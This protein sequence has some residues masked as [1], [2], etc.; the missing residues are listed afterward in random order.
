MKPRH[1]AIM[2]TQP[3]FAPTAVESQFEFV[4]AGKPD[5]FFYLSAWHS[6]GRR[7]DREA[8]DLADEALH[9]TL[10]G[11]RQPVAYFRI[12][13][14]FPGDDPGERGWGIA[15]AQPDAMELARRFRASHIWKFTAETVA[16]IRV[17]SGEVVHT[18]P[19][20]SHHR[21]PRD[22]RY[23]TLA[24]GSPPDRRSLAPSEI[25]DVRT[26]IG[27][28]FPGFTIQRAEGCFRTLSEETLLIHIATH[29]PTKVIALAHDLRLLLRQT[30][31]GIVHNGI[32][33]RVREWTDDGMILE[34]F[35]M[36]L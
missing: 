36:A 20:A 10:R 6:D 9:R 29:E 15:C 18:G 11:Q 3:P 31:I 14:I 16:V 4:A 23:L 30:G 17:E 24:V 5:S 13:R 2:S 26:R 35:G 1:R 21:D 22:V 32:Y 33:Q 7:S 25:A 27:A 34:T 19:R 12:L 28:S 8:N